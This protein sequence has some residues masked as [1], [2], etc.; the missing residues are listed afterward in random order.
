MNRPQTW[1]GQGYLVHTHQAER[2]AG[3]PSHRFIAAAWCDAPDAFDDAV[4]L[5]LNTLG[6]TF[7]YSRDV[8]PAQ[9][10]LDSFTD[11]KDKTEAQRLAEKIGPDQTTA[12]SYLYAVDAE[13]STEEQSY[14][15]IETLEG[16]EPLDGQFG[17]YPR[18]TVPDKLYEPLFGQPE[19]TEEEIEHYGGKENVPPMKLYAILDA[20]KVKVPGLRTMLR[21]SGLDFACLFTGQQY[22]TLKDSAPYIVELEEDNPFT[23][24]LFTHDP[25]MPDELLNAHL[26]HK[27]LGIYIRSRAN[28]RELG[29]HFM[30][31]VRVQ[32]EQ[33]KRFL[34]RFW[35]AETLRTIIADFNAQQFETFGKQIHTMLGSSGDGGFILL[36]RS[37][38]AAPEK[39]PE[40]I[41][42]PIRYEDFIN[43]KTLTPFIAQRIHQYENKAID[44]L[45]AEFKPA[46]RGLSDDELHKVAQ[47]AYFHAKKR[48]INGEQ[49]HLKYLIPVMFWGSY[50]EIDPQYQAQ[51]IRAGW[52]DEQGKPLQNTTMAPVLHEINRWADAVKTDNEHPQRIVQ[53]FQRLYQTN[54]DKV[55]FEFVVRWLKQAWPTRFTFMSKQQAETFTHRAYEIAHG[56]NFVE[57]D[58]TAYTCLAQYFG[59]R[60]VQDPLYPWAAKALADDGRQAEERR[61]ALGEAV[62]EHWKHMLGE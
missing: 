45:R 4:R 52:L 11:P 6:L 21:T 28:L 49:D 25:K 8:Q 62:L 54:P 44:F 30:Q 61:L 31:F 18:K 40:T 60:F 59:Y 12:I 57:V 15:K 36:T 33:G 27:E 58:G 43:D 42:G 39:R 46:T 47:L 41:N 14:L 17:V 34:F 3:R 2:Q 1:L 55:T 24:T 7:L 29:Q 9:Q 10:G 56:L 38:P 20:A 16:I 50:F 51:L 13:A 23:R 48:G 37:N 19:P 26:W 35:A 32:D 53:V 5:H 22:E